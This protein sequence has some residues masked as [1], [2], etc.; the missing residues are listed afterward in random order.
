[1]NA[2]VGADDDWRARGAI[3][4]DA[5]VNFNRSTSAA[6]RKATLSAMQSSPPSDSWEPNLQLILGGPLMVTRNFDV[7]SGVA[8]GTLG[9][10]VDVQI[11]DEKA[12]YF[13]TSSLVHVTSVSNVS[14]LVNSWLSA[15]LSVCLLDCQP[16]CLIV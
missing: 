7:V 3:R 14:G 6:D 12:V 1:M 13:D 5:C 10:L 4:I 2:A 11:R 9:T 15:C 8:N 16:V